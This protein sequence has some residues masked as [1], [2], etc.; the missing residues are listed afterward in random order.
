MPNEII[1]AFKEHYFK[2][3]QPLTTFKLYSILIK[4]FLY[5]A[6]GNLAMSKEMVLKQSELNARG[7]PTMMLPPNSC[8][9]TAFTSDSPVTRIV[10]QSC[11][12]TLHFSQHRQQPKN[13]PPKRISSAPNLCEPLPDIQAAQKRSSRSGTKRQI[14]G[15]RRSMKLTNKKASRRVRI[16]MDEDRM[17]HFRNKSGGYV[18]PALSKSIDDDFVGTAK[19]HSQDNLEA[20]QELDYVAALESLN[21]LMRYSHRDNPSV[22]VSMLYW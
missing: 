18:N 22:S 12:D 15:G 3:K 14:I 2:L 9:E 11:V 19:M 6:T 8:F 13:I 7:P 1:T 4:V 16:G 17:C 10:P 20:E 5:V 21:T